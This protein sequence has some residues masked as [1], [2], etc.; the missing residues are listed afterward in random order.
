ML[1]MDV[2]DIY[3]DRYLINGQTTQKQTQYKKGDKVRM[4]IINAGASTYF[5]LQYAG[6][7][8]NVIANDGKDVEPVE[9]DRLIIGNGETY[10]IVLTIPDNMSYELKVTPEDRIKFAS[11]FM[12]DGMEMKVPEMKGLKYF[13]GM[14]SMNKMMGSNGKMKNMGMKMSM[15]QMDMNAVMYQIGRASCRERVWCLV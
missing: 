13:E 5:W 8:I 6:G 10:D 9:V 4:R 15:Q 7:K 12:G 3:Y 11:I 14:K 1:S 2:S